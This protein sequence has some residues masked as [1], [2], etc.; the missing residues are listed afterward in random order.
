AIGESL[1]EF[2]LPESVQLEVCRLLHTLCDLQLRHRVEQVVKF[3]STFVKELQSDQYSRYM[4]IK[5]S[6]LPSSV[7][8]RRTREFR[9]P[10]AVQMSC[11]LRMPGPG[12]PTGRLEEGP[13]TTSEEP[14]NTEPTEPNPME[15]PG[16]E[17]KEGEESEGED[18]NRCAEEVKELLRR[19]HKH[20]TDKLGVLRP[21][22][23]GADAGE[24]GGSES[25][26]DSGYG[27]NSRVF[28]VTHAPD[29]LSLVSFGQVYPPDDLQTA[30]SRLPLVPPDMGNP[31]E[32]S[33]VPPW[34]LQAAWNLIMKKRGY[35]PTEDEQKELDRL[36]EAQ[37]SEAAGK[38]T[39]TDLIT[40]TIVKWAR[41]KYIENLELIREMF[42]VLYRQYNAIEEL[43]GAL[44]KTYVISSLSQDEVSRLLR[45]LGR[46]RCLLGVQLGSNEEMLLKNCL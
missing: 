41:S 2:P 3:A 19:F 34:I 22:S 9:C 4:A 25:M 46:V 23:E 21:G 16:D 1:L 18:T 26:I 8:A 35:S 20:L 17:N 33:G 43:R 5:L 38:N 39:F 10:A 27:D 13:E 32:G 6:N 42:S 24:H 12:G 36:Y 7:A 45:S 37:K 29:N 15:E 11:L 31:E 40:R 28:P 14:T 30:L 44:A